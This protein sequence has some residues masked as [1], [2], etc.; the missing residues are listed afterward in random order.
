MDAVVNRKARPESAKWPQ[1]TE[2]LDHRVQEL[3]DST[4]ED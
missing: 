3:P 4:T 1:V 2:M